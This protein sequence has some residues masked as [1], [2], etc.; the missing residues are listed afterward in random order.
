MNE[1]MDMKDFFARRI[2]ELIMEKNISEHQASH[3]L[4]LSKG[5][6][7]TITSKKNYPSF[8]HFFEICEYFDITPA[9]F[10]APERNREN[11]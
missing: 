2:T 3:D 7:Q 10:F 1:T 4:G 9:E 5:Y 6:I 11:S 8:T